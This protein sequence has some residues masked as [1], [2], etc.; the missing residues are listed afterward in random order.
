MD[1]SVCALVDLD[2]RINVRYVPCYHGLMLGRVY[3][4]LKIR[5]GTNAHLQDMIHNRR[6][7]CSR[8]FSDRQEG[9]DSDAILRARP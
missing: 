5:L 6:V 2:E 8:E 4:Q 3:G 1:G 7:I 9:C